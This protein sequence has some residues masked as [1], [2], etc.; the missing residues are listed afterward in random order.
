MCGDA[1]L[2]CALSLPSSLC[3]LM[4]EKILHTERGTHM[5]GDR[6]AGWLLSHVNNKGAHVRCDGRQPASRSEAIAVASKHAHRTRDIWVCMCV[7][8]VVLGEALPGRW[9]MTAHVA[10]KSARGIHPSLRKLPPSP[11]FIVLTG[12]P[13]LHSR[14]RDSKALTHRKHTQTDRQ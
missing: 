10:Q 4:R 6:Q 13:G 3:D 7:S 11:S 14:S 12:R 2:A 5:Q 1:A 9:W 8:V